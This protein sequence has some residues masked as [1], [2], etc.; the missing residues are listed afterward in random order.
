[1]ESPEL[2]LQAYAKVYANTGATTKGVDS[3]TMDGFSMERV[4]NMMTLLKENR[5]HFKPVRRA[6]IPKANGKQR[7]LGMPMCHAYCISLPKVLGIAVALP[8]SMNRLYRLRQY[9]ELRVADQVG[10]CKNRP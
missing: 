3:V 6:Y 1:M 10:S 5:Y 7:P 8:T 2:W 9:N 4:A